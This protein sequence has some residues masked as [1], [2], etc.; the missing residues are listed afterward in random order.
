MGIDP[1]MKRVGISSGDDETGLAS[2]YKTLL[3]KDDP[4]L[5]RDLIAEARS[6]DAQTVVVGL[7]LRMNGLEGPES[8]RARGLG[9]ALAE[10][11]KLN[12]VMWDER[13]TTVA[14]ER[15]LRGVGMRGDKKKGMIDQ[16][17]ATLLLQ[18]YLDAQSVRR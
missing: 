18:S 12:V 1:G 5:L 11:G 9:K 10:R 4:S 16:A 8:K 7:P 13:L 2:P 3:R 6:L 17:A 14:A 15:E